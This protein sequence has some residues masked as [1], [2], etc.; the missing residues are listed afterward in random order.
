MT[1]MKTVISIGDLGQAFPDAAF[2]NLVGLANSPIGR[3]G[4]GSGGSQITFPDSFKND[5][6]KWHISGIR[7]DPSAPGGSDAIRKQFGTSPQI[8]LI[9]NPVRMGENLSGKVPVV[10]DFAI[11]LIYTYTSGSDKPLQPGCLPRAKPNVAAFKEIIADFA[12]LKSDLGS[13]QFGGTSVQTDG[14]PL[15][16][17]PGLANPATVAAVQD[18]IKEILLRH[19]PKGRLSAMAVMGLPNGVPEP[20]IFLAL[21]LG[22]DGK[23]NPVPSP[24]AIHEDHAL[25]KKVLGGQEKDPK[26]VGKLLFSQMLS[27][28]DRE[29]V[30][31]EP[32]N[33]NQG[34]ITC[35]FFFMPKEARKGVSTKELF[36]DSPSEERVRTIVDVIADPTKSHFFN[37]DCISCHTE[38]RR[39]MDLLEDKMPPITSIDK[40]VLPQHRWNVRNFGWFKSSQLSIGKLRKVAA[41]VARRTATETAEVVECVNHIDECFARVP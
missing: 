6:A 34:D 39:E 24:S 25:L 22:A 29:P 11:H 30:A 9:L 13:G 12:K 7:I 19:L 36:T 18:R 1:D 16:V 33:N 21:Q 14:M 4:S 17:H 2:A 5:K 38:T 15:G 10:E 40:N 23:Y 27:F 32:A 31:P 41:T 26:E 37:T 3:V 20:W 8:R 35:Q 28:V